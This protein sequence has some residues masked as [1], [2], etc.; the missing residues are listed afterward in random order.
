MAE[1]RGGVSGQKRW[2]QRLKNP[3]SKI[4][5]HLLAAEDRYALLADEK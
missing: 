3:V 1:L 2:S 4:Y 5:R